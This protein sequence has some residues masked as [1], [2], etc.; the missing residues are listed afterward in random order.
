MKRVSG[1]VLTLFIIVFVVVIYNQKALAD[2][3]VGVGVGKI[4]IQEPIKAGGIYRLPEIVVYNTGDQ[5]AKYAMHLTLNETQPELKPD[6][7]WFS[8]EPASFNLKPQES[9]IVT[10][11]FT[12]PLSTPAGDYYGYL[13][14]Y[15]DATTEQGSAKIGV[16]AATKL[17]FKVISSSRSQAIINRIK[18][19][20]EKF[21]PA[22]HIFSALLI[23]VALALA[24]RK[25]IKF[26]IK[27]TAGKK[28]K[29]K[30]KISDNEDS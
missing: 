26:D 24:L 5:D 20:Y 13:E 16:A 29:K 11:I 9:R 27:I 25:F 28:Q 17:R 6:P 15:P 10:P 3:G 4:D 22:S 19:L 2:I 12:P 14:A 1:L 7:A 21:T 23:L 30:E 18:A 8:F